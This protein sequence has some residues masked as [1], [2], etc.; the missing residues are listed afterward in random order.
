MTISRT[1]FTID[2]RQTVIKKVQTPP[3]VGFEHLSNKPEGWKFD[4]RRWCSPFDLNLPSLPY[5]LNP[6]LQGIKPKDYF[7][8][9]VESL[10]EDF[11]I[12]IKNVGISWLPVTTSSSF[13]FFNQDYFYYGDSSIIEYINESSNIDGR[14][15]ISLSNSPSMTKPVLAA[16]FKRDENNIPCYWIRVNQVSEFT[17]EDEDIETIDVYSKINWSNVDTNKKE[18]FVD[19]SSGEAYL[20]FNNDYIQQIGSVPSDYV[21]LGLCEHIGISDGE[22]TLYKTKCFPLIPSDFHLYV[23]DTTAETFV[24]WTR[25]DSWWELQ[26]STGNKYFLDKDLGI[27]HF[28][29]TYVPDKN[30]EILVTYKTTLRIE[31]EKED[32]NILTAYKADVNPLTTHKNQGFVC[33]TN[34]PL[35]VAEIILSV[36][37]TPISG[38]YDPTEFG[39]VYAGAD[40]A[41]FSAKAKTID[42]IPVSGEQITFEIISD[43]IGS[44]NNGSY[45]MGLTNGEGKAY[46]PYQSPTGVDDLGFYSTIERTSNHIFYTG[47]KELIISDENAGIEDKE[48]SIFTYQILKDDIVLGYD[49]VDDYLSTLTSPSWVVD[50]A[51]YER[52]KQEMILAYGWKDWQP[53]S[54]EGDPIDGRKVVLYKIDPSTENY[55]ASAIHPVNGTLGAVVPVR[56]YLTEKIDNPSDPYYGYY[57]VIYPSAALPAVTG[58]VAGYWIGTERLVTVKASAWSGYYSKTIYSNPITLR[59]GIPDYLKGEVLNTPYGWKLLDEFN[60]Y[61]AGFGHTFITVNS[62]NNP[63][64]VID[65]LTGE[66]TERYVNTF[67]SKGLVFSIE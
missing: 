52:W 6:S 20:W 3:Y 47:E 11:L 7:Q 15:F 28:N 54:S 22:S 57:R 55:D 60:Y 66:T 30:D 13:Y 59:I 51:T 62:N 19:R 61:A 65:V 25:V 29:E 23:A 46:S 43:Q 21:D 9:G 17:R 12:S 1:N 67:N 34:N 16:T 58:N 8:S 10:E 45:S 35:E 42:G 48:N 2:L 26:S 36:N 37:K 31:Y 32:E 38:T 41:M 4:I 18:F 33:I 44:L 64:R 53:P 49:S 24:E 40:F 50:S 14:N 39:P 27:I 63:Y 5:S 56:P